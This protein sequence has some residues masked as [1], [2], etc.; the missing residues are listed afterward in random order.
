MDSEEDN[1]DR[2]TIERLIERVALRKSAP[3]GATQEQC[4]SRENEIREALRDLD[5]EVWTH[6]NPGETVASARA[7]VAPG[8]VW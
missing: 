3:L 2:E 7:R 1:M 8:V 5:E 4:E 6:R